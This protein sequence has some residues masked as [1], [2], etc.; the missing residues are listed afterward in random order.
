MKKI[1][2]LTS[3]KTFK[4]SFFLSCYNLLWFPLLFTTPFIPKIKTG[5]KQR[6]SLI[7]FPKADIL[8]QAA[9][10]GEAYLAI[11]LAK[12]I[13]KINPSIKILVSTHTAQGIEVLKKANIKTVFFPFD[14]LPL[15]KKFLNNVAPKIT[16]VLETEIWPNF[17]FE[18]KKKNI[19]LIII[20]GR[21]SR[22]TFTHYLILK[23]FISPPDAIL[24]ISEDDAKRFKFIFQDS[25]VKI[26]PNLKFENINPKGPIP[27]IKN[28]LNSI[29]S[30]NLKLI[31]FGSIRLAE[32][33]DIL[34]VIKHYKNKHPKTAF[35]IFPRHLNR[36][37]DLEKKLKKM[38]LPYTLRSK[39]KNKIK[40]GSIVLW[41]KIGELVFTYAL[42]QKAFV[43]GS[44]AP[45]GGQNFLEPLSQG[46]KPIIGPYWTNFTW[47]GEEVFNLNLAKKVKNKQELLTCLENSSH[48]NRNEI[49]QKF[50]TYL[51]TKKGGL[52]FAINY[53][54]SILRIY[55]C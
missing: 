34:W 33:D 40:P 7:P 20:N 50:T 35:T 29:I 21:M 11:L 49:F 52:N 27:Y 8:I 12:K 22:K 5:L 16:I 9:S 3:N 46:I 28:P 48:F 25:E 1:N 54:N 13:Q 15:I 53:I 44:L 19:P 17:Y 23:N 6:L 4:N 18:C 51:K 24:A 10:V 43:G 55:P 47:V 2:K 45:Y 26:M 14:F 37:N 39:L 30:P 41:D 32:Q 42:A 36:I 31:V 38:N